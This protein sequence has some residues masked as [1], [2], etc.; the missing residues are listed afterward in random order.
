MVMKKEYIYNQKSYFIQITLIAYFC[1]AA[2]L[3]SLVMIVIDYK[4]NIFIMAAVVSVYTVW[5]TFISHSNP[6]KVILE[7]DGISFESYGKVFKY[8]FDEIT[9]FLAK[10]FRGSGKI[11]LRI[12]QHNFFQ[13]RFWIH[14]MEFNDS[15]E[16]FLYLLKLE[17]KTHPNSIKA[18]AWDSTR[19]EVNKMPILPWNIPQKEE[20]LL[21]S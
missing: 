11:F 5:N 16:L 13:G 19:P 6:G 15:E 17:Y 12:N 3:F 10:D 2:F 20:Q 4:R 9:T 14:T 18:R 21:K 8:L 1:A 7:E